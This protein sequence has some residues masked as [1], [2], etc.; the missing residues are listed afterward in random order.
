V[1]GIG[2]LISGGTRFSAQGPRRMGF[3]CN[4]SHTAGAN[5]IQTGPG[6]KSKSETLEFH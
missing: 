1:L 6:A 3:P 4:R 5:L 2:G